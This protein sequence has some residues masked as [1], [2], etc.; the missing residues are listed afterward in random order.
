MFKFKG[1]NRRLRTITRF[2]EPIHLRLQKILD[3]KNWRKEQL[4]SG[5]RL[6]CRVVEI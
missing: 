4:K 1:L 2:Q 6:L 5:A 3:Q